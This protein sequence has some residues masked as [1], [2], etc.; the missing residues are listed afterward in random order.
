MNEKIKEILENPQIAECT[1]DRNGDYVV[2]MR[3]GAINK[4]DYKGNWIGGSP[5]DD[6]DDD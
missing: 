2:T 5:G 1:R 4:Y 3:N 6:E